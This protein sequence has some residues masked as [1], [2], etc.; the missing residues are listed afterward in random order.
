MGLEDTNRTD[1][2]DDRLYYF[3]QPP[4]ADVRD[5]FR[6]CLRT[7]RDSSP[8]LRNH[9]RSNGTGIQSLSD[10]TQR[11]SAGALVNAVEHAEACGG[12]WCR[13]RGTE[14]RARAR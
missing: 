12:N 6:T 14:H 13:N 9:V 10:G 4:G 1:I 7:M 5:T 8:C 11:H 3:Q 2:G